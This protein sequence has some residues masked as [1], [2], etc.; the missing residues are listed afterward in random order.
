MAK[1][2]IDRS[3]KPTPAKVKQLVLEE[4]D[5]GH[6]LRVAAVYSEAK[7]KY[8]RTDLAFDEQHGWAYTDPTSTKARQFDFRFR[9][10]CSNVSRGSS[11]M[12]A[13]PAHWFEFIM[14]RMIAEALARVS[15]TANA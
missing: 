13:A 2:K 15:V 9:I 1:N 5:F 6:E 8:S 7:S 10:T 14:A 4:D 3:L 12:L 11:I